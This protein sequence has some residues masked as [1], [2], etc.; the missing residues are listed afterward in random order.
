MLTVHGL[1]AIFTCKSIY[2]SLM[3]ESC[4]TR[5]DPV[6]ADLIVTLKKQR[7]K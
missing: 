5:L 6:D 2:R 7:K 3:F 4:N 1:Q